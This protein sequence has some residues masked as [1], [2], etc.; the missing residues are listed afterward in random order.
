MVRPLSPA[1]P[2]T[3]P[4]PFRQLLGAPAAGLRASAECRCGRT[5]AAG[6][7]LE[8]GSAAGRPGS[9]MW[10]NRPLTPRCTEAR[11]FGGWAGAN[12]GPRLRHPRASV[13]QRSPGLAHGEG[14]SHPRGACLMFFPPCLRGQESGLIQF[15][16]MSL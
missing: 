5:S 12:R 4:R 16:K 9:G 8:A 7:G 11:A 15:R 2:P 14:L 10:G 13:H 1:E 3:P 6:P